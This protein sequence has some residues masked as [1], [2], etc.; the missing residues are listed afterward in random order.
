MCAD[1]VFLLMYKVERFGLKHDN[2]RENENKYI[3]IREG[4]MEGKRVD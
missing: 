2:G 1:T 4:R 3:L